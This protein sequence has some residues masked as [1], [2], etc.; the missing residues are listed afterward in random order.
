MPR[1]VG[2]EVDEALDA[3]ADTFRRRGYSRTSIKTLEEETGLS[4]GSLNNS[5]GDK[6]AI[7]Q[8]ALGHYVDTVVAK[9]LAKHLAHENPLEGLRA[10]F[11]TLLKEP[12]GG[13]FG[14]LLTNT[15][16]EFG[17][18][19]SQALPELQRGLREQEEAFLV[20]VE[21]LSPGRP[22]AKAFAR[23][24][25]ALYQGVLVLVRAGYPKQALREAIDLEFDT[26]EG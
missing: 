25:L 4:S 7:F 3:A 5:F 13:S 23:R 16:I 2:F 9:R 24:L 26:F 20:A 8:L 11:M 1:S 10:L 21:R 19:Q 14:C 22:N 18:A 12:G 15:A 6:G 17:P